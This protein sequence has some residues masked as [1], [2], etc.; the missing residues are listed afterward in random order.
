MPDINAWI[1]A[2]GKLYD[3][4]GYLIV[5]L[6]AMAENTAFLGLVLPGGTLALLGA[7][8]ARQ[9]TLSLGLVILFAWL[10]TVVGYSLDY[11][12]GRFLL[13]RLVE[14]WGASPLGRR[15]R[16]VARLRQARAFLAKHGGKA[17]LL[18]HTVGHVRSFVALTAGA[19]RMRYPRFLAFELVAAL[20][21]NTGYSLLGYFLGAQRERIQMLIERSGWVMLALVVA[22]YL[23]WRFGPPRLR[24]RFPW[25][26]R[27][28]GQTTRTARMTRTTTEAMEAAGGSRRKGWAEM[29]R[30]VGG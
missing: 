19:T 20:L 11:L 8:Y 12:L 6:G 23:F 25:L 16:L 4:Y 30:R 27:R 15:M 3:Q 9:G 1:E 13:S 14:R 7:F 21:W 10:G 29:V 22:L 28:L 2:L 17:I 18:S 26:A 24:E 5:F